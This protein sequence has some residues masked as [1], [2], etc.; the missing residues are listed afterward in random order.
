[1]AYQQQPTYPTP[2]NSKKIIFIF[3]HWFD[4]NSFLLF[5]VIILQPQIQVTKLQMLLVM[6][7]QHMGMGHHLHTAISHPQ[8]NTL[9][10]EALED[11]LQIN[12]SA[13]PVGHQVSFLTYI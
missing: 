12:P 13:H 10:Q 4:F 7:S 8:V 9:H 2:Y 5:K 1:M 6:Y 11:Q 3:A